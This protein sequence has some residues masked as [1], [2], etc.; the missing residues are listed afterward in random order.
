MHILGGGGKQTIPIALH[1]SSMNKYYNI[2][3]ECKPARTQMAGNPRPVQDSQAS[4]TERTLITLTANK[5]RNSECQK[6]NQNKTTRHYAIKLGLV[7]ATEE[8]YT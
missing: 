5:R 1:S 7:N 4:A 8:Q 3:G 6:P 2:K